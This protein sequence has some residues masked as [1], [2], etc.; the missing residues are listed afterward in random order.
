MTL[1]TCES[2]GPH[3]NL[4]TYLEA[5]KIC[6]EAVDTIIKRIEP[7]MSEKVAQALIKDTFKNFGASK[8][9]HPSKFRIAA[10]S[11]KNFSETSNPDLVCESGDL[12]FV[13]VGPVINQHEADYG[14]SFIL[15]NGSPQKIALVN[16]SESIFL[17]TA[18]FWKTNNCTGLELYA[19]ASEQAEKLG[20]T[21]NTRMAGHRL[22]DFPHKVFSSQKLNKLEKVPVE[23]LWVL[24]IHLIDE[25]SH[26]G[27][28]FE[29]ILF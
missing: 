25:K 10:D 19:F 12:C 21:L 24:E 17:D 1:E 9:W 20:Y 5:R 29:D 27:A 14:R 23:N 3:F 11:V 26:Q 4:N 16:A 2:T 6:I 28:F 13:D 22:G 8:F 15:G 18:K 7:G